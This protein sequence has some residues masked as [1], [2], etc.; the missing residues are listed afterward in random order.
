MYLF[1]GAQGQSQSMTRPS[2]ENLI[3]NKAVRLVSDHSMVDG[4]L[5]EVVHTAMLNSLESGR[6]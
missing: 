2:L 1:T 3:T 4:A 6:T 5:D